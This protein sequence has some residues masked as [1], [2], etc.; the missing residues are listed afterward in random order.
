[1]ELLEIDEVRLEFGSAD[2]NGAA[3]KD[4]AGGSWKFRWVGLLADQDA[5]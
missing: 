4:A 2:E 3:A 1:M 5:G